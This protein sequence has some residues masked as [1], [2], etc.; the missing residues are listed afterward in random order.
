MEV[1]IVTFLVPAWLWMCARFIKEL[2]IMAHMEE[3]QE[4]WREN[5]QFTSDKEQYI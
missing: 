1:L 5:P 3:R 2:Q 4:F